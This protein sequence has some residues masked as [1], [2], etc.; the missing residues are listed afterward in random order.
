MYSGWHDGGFAYF[1]SRVGFH[2]LTERRHPEVF[3][4]WIGVG[5]FVAWGPLGS[6][7][8][9]RLL[10]ASGTPGTA[11]FLIYLSDG[12]GYLG[13]M[14]LLVYHGVAKSAA[15]LEVLYVWASGLL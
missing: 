9:E 15:G 7:M 4:I 13:T 10:A 8:F 11:I 3:I 2:E 1:T 5:F 12:C 14:S 6:L